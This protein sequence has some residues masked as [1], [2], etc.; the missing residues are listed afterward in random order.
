M[1]GLKVL[2]VA[3]AALFGY[4]NAYA[5]QRSD[6]P[7][8]TLNDGSSVRLGE[9][10]VAVKAGN[11][12]HRSVL[13]RLDNLAAK[14]GKAR[15]FIIPEGEAAQF[16]DAH[17]KMGRQRMGYEHVVDRYTSVSKS[18]LISSQDDNPAYGEAAQRNKL[19]AFRSKH[20]EMK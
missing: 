4:A 18:T 2:L 6:M 1:A 13:K 10:D 15:P 5:Y 7:T 16:K 14:A 11:K 3:L 9:S 12:Y 19:S 8:V 20:T 17:A